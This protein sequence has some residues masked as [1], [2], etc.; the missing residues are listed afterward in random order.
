MSETILVL[1]FG[2][3][4]KELIARSV[5]SLSV[6]SEIKPGSLSVHEI[7]RINPIGIILTGGP[8]S[9]YLPDAPKCNPALFALDIP[10]LGICYGMQMMC[11]TLGGKVDPGDAGEYGRVPVTITKLSALF[12]EEKQT[13]AA[14]MSH[15]D[16]VTHLPEGFMSTAIT[17]HCTAACENKRKKLYGVQFHPETKHTEGGR[18]IIRNFLYGICKATGEYKLDNYIETQITQIRQRVGNNNVLLGLS[19]GVDSSVCA[20]LLSQAIP[21]QLTCIFVDHGF[22]RL[23]EGDEIERVFAKRNLR[24]IR[25]NAKTR[26]LAKLKGAYRS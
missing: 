19:G 12:R 7:Q 14:L 15:R 24:F 11:H 9:V 6:H 18:E 10:I 16:I 17:A 3:Q 5:R 23:N 20:N 21:G 1:D 25:V 13:F 8:N 22:M 4:Y 26:F 2:G